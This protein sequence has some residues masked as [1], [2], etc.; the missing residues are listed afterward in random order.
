MELDRVGAKDVAIDHLVII[1]AREFRDSEKRVAALAG[2]GGLP[3]QNLWVRISGFGA[4]ST[5][6][7][8]RH[9]IEAARSLQDLDLPLVLDMAGGFAGLSALAF[10]AFGGISHGAGQRESFD[11]AHWRKPPNGK[12]GGT[13]LRAYVPDLDR[14]LT[15]EQLQAFFAI[16]GTK[17]R[18][19]CADSSCCTHGH[20]D[21]LENGHAHFITQRCR[22]LE[23]L[24]KVPPSRRAENFLLRQLD[25]AVRSTRQASKLKFGDN[26]VQKLVVDAKSRLTRLRD[27]LGALH[28]ADSAA[29]PISAS[30]LFRGNR[31]GSGGLS[32][33]QGGRP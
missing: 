30:P 2:V 13:S 3:V 31:P 14:Y 25:P 12:G 1:G 27:A 11:L 7:R 33:L 9:V 18:F 23:A 28:E 15:E 10:G 16:R 20:E 17:A 19:A 22:Q 8:T 5:G 24:S 32:V 26:G 21:M 4:T 6:A 29:A